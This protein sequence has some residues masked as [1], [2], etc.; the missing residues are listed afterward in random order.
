MADAKKAMVNILMDMSGRFPPNVIFDDWIKCLAIAIQ[1][2]CV[3]VTDEVFSDR[4]EQY[5]AVIS[6]YD[7]DIED[8]F[9]QMTA[10][11]GFA[12]DEKTE[13]VLGIV[14]MEASMGNKNAGQFFTPSGISAIKAKI[15]ASQI[16]KGLKK[17]NKKN[18]RLY[19]PTSGSGGII[20]EI[21]RELQKRGIDYSRHICVTAQ[22]LDWRCVYMTYIQLSLLDINAVV[23]QGDCIE[24]PFEEG[25]E[26]PAHRLF[27]TPK[28]MER[29]K[30]D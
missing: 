18:Y 3:K 14:Y 28:R 4:E 21:V 1:N 29:L 2:S 22:D 24:E 23:A 6:K 12:L 5:R 11:L 17:N 15:T 16:A 30:H 13:D 8:I 25:N 10:L 20:M 7:S 26:Y 27:I 9:S 19:E